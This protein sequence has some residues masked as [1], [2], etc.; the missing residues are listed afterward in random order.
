L[1]TVMLLPGR[2]LPGLAGWLALPGLA[3]LRLPGHAI[4][5]LAV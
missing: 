1:L 2:L 4:L 5:R 3:I